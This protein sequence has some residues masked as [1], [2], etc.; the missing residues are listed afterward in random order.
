[1][2]K[3]SAEHRRAALAAFALLALSGCALRPVAE[4]PLLLP[5]DWA[6]RRD[7][8]QQR[9]DFALRGR[10]AVAAGEQ[11]FSA[12]LRWIQHGERAQIRLDGPLGLGALEIENSAGALIVTT[13]R[14]DRLD[15]EA[16]RLELERQLGVAL[17]LD[18]LRYWVQGLPS[19]SSPAT[20]S[21]EADRPRLVRLEQQGWT[22]DYTEYQPAPSEHRPRR[23]VAKG[24]AARVRLLI[25]SWQP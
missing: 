6:A 13:G 18:S 7:I 4:L 23:L 1:M 20:E 25:E 15:G 3:R 24:P 19:P 11:G 9:P 14:G 5:S 12:S 10:V 2:T 17:P 21:L 8:L 16:A 22:V